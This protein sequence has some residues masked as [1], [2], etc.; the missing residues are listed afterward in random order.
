MIISIL[1]TILLQE[2]GKKETFFLTSYMDYISYRYYISCRNV[3]PIGSFPIKI[4]I[5]FQVLSNPIGFPM[6]YDYVNE[7]QDNVNMYFKSKLMTEVRV[8]MKQVSG[9]SNYFFLI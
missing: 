9:M 6:F 1:G 4:K 8:N 7:C 5:S 2:K 3:I